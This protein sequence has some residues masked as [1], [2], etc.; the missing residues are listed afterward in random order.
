MP[1]DFSP[2]PSFSIPTERLHIS[3]I[4]PGNP[5]HT[6]FFMHVWNLEEIKR[7]IGKRDLDTLEKVDVFIKNQVQAEYNRAGYGRFLVSLK[8]HPQASLAESKHI[9]L[10][11]LILREP[12]NGYPHPDIGYAFVPEHWGKGYATE[13]A[14]A[15]INYAR[16]EFG[17]TGVFGRRVLE[18]IGLE[19]RGELT[20]RAFDGIQSAVYALPGMNPDLS[21]YGIEG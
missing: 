11:S 21:V 19:F 3:Y 1:T 12:P 18:K 4:Q 20:L 8:P 14:I 5:D 10:V 9:G 17:V 15:L 7:F 6:S 13:A 2:P 16:R